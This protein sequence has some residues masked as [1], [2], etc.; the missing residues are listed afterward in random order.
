MTQWQAIAEA[1][2]DFK[3]HTLIELTDRVN[4]LRLSAGEKPCLMTAVSARWRE[5]SKH[6]VETMP[7][8]TKKEA[9]NTYYYQRKRPTSITGAEAERI[10]QA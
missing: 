4:A 9:P 6:G 10:L 1:L 3:P 7:L 5:L 8:T 2:N